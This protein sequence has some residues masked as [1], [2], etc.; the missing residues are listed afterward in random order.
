[1]TTLNPTITDFSGFPNACTEDDRNRLL[2]L[3]GRLT[4][5]A[6]LAL[7][8]G[9]V[10]GAN[11]SWLTL[12]GITCDA[13]F[14]EGTNLLDLAAPHAD[15]QSAASLESSL[16]SLASS[17]PAN[18]LFDFRF[19]RDGVTQT[20]QVAVT[21][22]LAP[23]AEIVA[24]IWAFA[25]ISNVSRSPGT[26]GKHETT[27]AVARISADITHEFNNFL[28]PVIGSIELNQAPR[29]DE[30]IGISESAFVTDQNQQPP[31]VQGL[32]DTTLGTSGRPSA[33]VGF[34][35]DEPG[36]CRIAQM[37]LELQGHDAAVY[38]SGK[39]LL[40]AIADGNPLD[41]V[42]LDCCMPEL[43]G[44]ETFRRLRLMGC[45]I[46][47]VVCSG[48]GVDLKTFYPDVAD[49]PTGFLAKPFTLA[50]LDDAINQALGILNEKSF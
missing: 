38:S 3:I 47:V 19:Q 41:L 44:A 33:R 25:D 8:D 18:R 49:Q 11:L 17:P 1:L 34:V 43:S 6:V 35:D 50:T 42:V 46:P 16:Q 29:P 7:P 28:T 39:Q 21:P 4:E 9:T 31:M 37:M 14:P 23:N 40:D 15:T 12:T 10:M 27:H 2:E 36:I 13:Q 48:S 32:F 30:P 24:A 22:L 45:F 26:D 5:P 20:W